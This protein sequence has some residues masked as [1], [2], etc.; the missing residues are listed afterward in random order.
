MLLLFDEMSMLGQ[1]MFGHLLRRIDDVMNGGVVATEYG[2]SDEPLLGLLC[3][4]GICGDH[5]QLIPV[6]GTC[7][8]FPVQP[9]TS[10]LKRIGH[11]SYRQLNTCF[12][13]DKPVIRIW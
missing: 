10:D 7:N 8:F 9:G 2:S 1:L 6:L 11:L 4:F 3:I 5:M 13:L 12:V